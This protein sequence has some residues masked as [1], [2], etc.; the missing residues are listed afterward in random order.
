MMSRSLFRI[1]HSTFRIRHSTFVRRVL[2]MAAGALVAGAV[3]L[4]AR[5]NDEGPS[6]R[7]IAVSVKTTEEGVVRGRLISLSLNDG[8]LVRLSSGK[9]QHIPLADL[10][11]IDAEGSV[12]PHGPRDLR[13]TLYGR[14]HL[15]G[16]IAGSG[17][18]SVVVE[19][20]DL[21][22]VEV[23]LEWIM[24]IDT[25]RAIQP[26]HRRSVEWFDRSRQRAASV[27]DYELP[28]APTSRST[29][30]ESAEDMILLTNG[31]VVRGFVTAIDAEGV[32]I[33]STL[34]ETKIPH[35]MVV[36][37]R[38]AGSPPKRLGRPHAI[39]TFRNSGRLTVTDIEW[40]GGMVH[41]GVAMRSGGKIRV[42]AERI[43]RVDVV[44]S[45]W[46]WLATQTPI[47]AQHTPMLALGYN[48]MTDRNV[49]GGPIKVAGETFE[50]GVGVHSQSSLTY[51]L[52]GAYGEFVT[53]FGIDDDSGPLADVSVRILIDG[54]PR[55]ERGNVRRGTL[56]GPVRLD[57]AGANRIELIVDFGLNGDLQDRFNWVEPALIRVRRGG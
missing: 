32:G 49:L 3:L 16:L 18:E 12:Q 48:H 43:V 7:A 29:A 56:H 27:A 36:S 57:V 41:A 19:T 9:E 54:K 4:P 8:A 5:G 46:E 51:D 15:Y 33:E 24:R 11:R 35:R 44:G 1:P 55:L 47:S 22:S 37:M 53:R 30:H 2:A 39:L 10:V 20:V 31:D 21:G 40:S 23:P 28:A 42:E 34:G 25:A 45:R 52:K 38:L 13:F 50:H 6:R 26:A 14:N 17:D